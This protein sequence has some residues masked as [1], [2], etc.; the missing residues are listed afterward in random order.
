M[1]S[2]FVLC[3]MSRG[4]RDI[5][6]F[7]DQTRAKRAFERYSQRGPTVLMAEPGH[8]QL[9]CTR[10]PAG[11]QVVRDAATAAVAGATYVVAAHVGF[12]CARIFGRDGEADASRFYASIHQRY[13]KAMWAAGNDAAMAAYGMDKWAGLCS[14]LA[15][16]VLAVAVPREAEEEGVLQE[17]VDAAYWIVG[18]FDGSGPRLS[19]FDNEAR[20]RKAFWGSSRVSSAVLVAEPDNNVLDTAGD[21]AEVREVTAAV[22][23]AAAGATYVVAKHIGYTV[24]TMH[25]ANDGEA[26][27]RSVYDSIPSGNA[28]TLCIAGRDS[29][30]NKSGED[31]WAGKCSNLAFAILG[32]SAAAEAPLP[33]ESDSSDVEEGAASASGSATGDTESPPAMVEAKYWLVGLTIER[34]GLEILKA[35]DS[36]ESA[37]RTYDEAVQRGMTAAV[38]MSQPGLD[39]LAASGDK[40][41]VEACYKAA[42]G[43][44]NSVHRVVSW[45]R[46]DHAEALLFTDSQVIDARREYA[47]IP[48][49]FPRSLWTADSE[50]AV[51]T[52]GHNI[53]IEVSSALATA[54]LTIADTPPPPI[55]AAPYYTVSYLTTSGSMAIKGYDTE[56]QARIAY[57]RL[58]EDTPRAL[59][60]QPGNLPVESSPGD[61]DASILTNTVVLATGKAT[62]NVRWVVVRRV[63]GRVEASLTPK[64]IES[65]EAAVA[66]YKL[67]KGS[68]ARGVWG[69]DATA[70]IESRGWTTWLGRCEAL[71][72]VILRREE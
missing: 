61:Q 2:F 46:E 36:A 66:V 72:A 48:R 70:A 13:A 4:S 11:E 34:N 26:V 31:I 52:Y 30:A 44:V 67:M 24:A 20:A 39:V 65:K 47:I 10:N 25:T 3:S 43:A 62:S 14:D 17:D 5:L 6:A 69:A 23:V 42:E 50:N 16:S 12:T 54:I 18:R 35:H 8:E 56:A 37:Q 59:A 71:A 58:D 68:K 45:Y 64:E 63:F 19:A 1:A 7:D 15:R 53:G 33:A 55:E 28:K 29:P 21:D 41:P 32:V 40:E 22:A 57:Q 60:G 51:A 27:A 49:I 9:A 38:L